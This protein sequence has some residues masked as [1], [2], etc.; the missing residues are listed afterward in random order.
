MNCPACGHP[1]EDPG[2]PF[3]SA[4]GAP[5]APPLPPPP[6]GALPSP[7]PALAQLWPAV[8]AG[9]DMLR[10][11]PSAIRRVVAT[12]AAMPNAIIVLAVVGLCWG[13]GSFG[14]FGV[15]VGP[16]VLL[17]GAFLEVGI[18]HIVA[19]LVGGRGDYATL[20]RV[21]GLLHVAGV[22]AVVPLAGGFLLGLASLWF[23]VAL[24]PILE[25]S[26][27]LSRDRAILTVAILFGIGV[28]IAIMFT[29]LVLFGVMSL[30][31]LAAG[32]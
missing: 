7:D 9:F 12:P 22:V 5:L 14:P 20:L 18:I 1:T 28:S 4:C 23:L 6:P 15:F 16:P 3:C 10:F 17:L 21:W 31:M 29:L 25:I 30:A 26:H 13:I 27:G 8:T 11:E 2:A 32:A 19:K 24:V